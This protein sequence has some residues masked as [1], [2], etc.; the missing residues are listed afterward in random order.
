MAFPA[1][2]ALCGVKWRDLGHSLRSALTVD[3]PAVTCPGRAEGGESDG[4]R[5]RERERESERASTHARTHT[6]T[7]DRRRARAMLLRYSRKLNLFFY[8]FCKT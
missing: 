1:L 4:S 7:L 2:R 8:S 5:T 6:E 3:S